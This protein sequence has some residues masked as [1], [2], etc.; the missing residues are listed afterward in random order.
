MAGISQQIPNYSR[1]M[2]E[3][4]DQLKLPGQVKNI[5]NGIPD[6]TYGYLKT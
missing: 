2:S 6:I 4:P 3:Q 5:V 1:G